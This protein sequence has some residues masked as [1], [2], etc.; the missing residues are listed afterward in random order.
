VVTEIV[1]RLTGILDQ[2]TIDDGFEV[3]GCGGRNR[4]RGHGVMGETIGFVS[5]R[6]VVG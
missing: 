1:P 3:G 6:L 2:G 5:G 4:G